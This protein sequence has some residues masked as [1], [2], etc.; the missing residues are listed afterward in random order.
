M[1]ILKKLIDK[2]LNTEVPPVVERLVRKTTKS[3]GKMCDVDTDLVGIDAEL[4]KTAQENKKFDKLFDKW[5]KLRDSVAEAKSQKNYQKVIDKANEVLVLDSKAKS[6]GIFVPM[7]EEDIANAYIKLNKVED[8]M[9][10][11]R[12]ALAG[13]KKEHEKTNGWVN[14]I[15]RIEAKILKL[16]SKEMK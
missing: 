5:L 13:Y 16:K 12:N 9:E 4:E 14:K 2:I 6:I 15:E 8:A 1:G 10:H 11:Y 3:N 7:F